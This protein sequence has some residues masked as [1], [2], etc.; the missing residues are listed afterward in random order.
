MKRSSKSLAACLI[1]TT[2]CAAPIEIAKLTPEQPSSQ[3]ARRPPPKTPP[4]DTEEG[5]EYFA[6]PSGQCSPELDG[7]FLPWN[8]VDKMILVQRQR[9]L[10]CKKTALDEHEKY[11]LEKIRR[12]VAE[13]V[14]QTAATDPLSWFGRFGMP[15]AAAS[16]VLG[17]ILGVCIGKTK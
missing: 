16:M 8:G 4:E 6:I 17:V 15:L 11:E 10:T 1:L 5:E 3:P 12:E 13:S 9:R 2:S 14:A 7:L